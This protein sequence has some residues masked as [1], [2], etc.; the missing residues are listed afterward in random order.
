[1]KV[2]QVKSGFTMIELIFVIVILGILAAVA[3]PKFAGVQG[4]AE[5]ATI[6]SFAGTLSRTVGP[7]MWSTSISEGLNGTISSDSD[8]A[9]FNGE[10]LPHYVDNFPKLLDSSTVNFDNCVIG[11]GVASPFIQK[12]SEGTLNIFCRDGNTSDSPRFVVSSAATYT[13]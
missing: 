8:S 10:E 12:N 4:Q 2:L 13:F 9:K 5:V 7:M 1:M 11:S 3:L 6:E